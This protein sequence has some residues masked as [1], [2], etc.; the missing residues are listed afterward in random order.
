MRGTKTNEK[1]ENVKRTHWDN[2]L[3]VTEK[4]MEGV[5]RPHQDPLVISLVIKKTSLLKVLF[6]TKA[7]VDIIYWDA[8]KN[9]HLKEEDLKPNYV[10]IKGFGETRVPIIGKIMILV[11]LGKDVQATTS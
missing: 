3:T 9:L 8:F 4:D 11:T 1:K 2:T 6:D 7:S 5:R 10:L